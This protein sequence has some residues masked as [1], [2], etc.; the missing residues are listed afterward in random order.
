MK[1]NPCWMMALIALLG[2]AIGQGSQAEP[3]PW[4]SL[5]GP[6]GGSVAALAM[7]PNYPIDHTVFAGLRGQGVYRTTD[8]GDSW[9]P[10][11]PGGWVV[12]DLAISPA[13]ADDQTVFVSTGLWTTGYHIYRSTDEGITWQD[14]TP[15]WSGLPNVPRLAISPDF[16]SDRTIYVLGTLQT[17]VSTDGGDTFTLATGWL[18]THNVSHL[19]FSPAYAMDHTLF[20][21]VPSDGLYK[22]SDGGTTWEATGS[23]DNLSTFAVSPDYTND[24]TLLAVL[25]SSGRLSVSTDG[26]NSWAENT[27]TPDPA[28]QHT[29]LFSPTFSSAD[30]VILAASS[31]DPGPY[32]SEDGGTTWSAVEGL[33]GGSV[34]ALALA[35]ASSFDAAAYAG[36]SSGIHRSWNRG[37]HWGQSS[38]G[39]PRLTIL[40][41]TIAPGDPDTMLAGTSFFE[42][43][44][45][46]T[47]TP[48]EYDGNLQLSTDGGQTWRAVSGQL[49]RVQNV[50]FSPDFVNDQSAFAATGTLGQHGYFGGNVY[51]S[52]DGGHN[53]SAVF[54]NLI[55]KALAISPNYAA[56]QTLWVS[57]FTDSAA[58]GIYVSHHGG[59][60]WSILTHDIHAEVLAP[61]PN[62][63]VDGTLF[64][65]TYDNGLQRSTD[66]GTLWTR[67]LN[68][69]VT[70]LAVSTAYGASRTLYVGVKDTPGTAG[71]IYRSSNGG[72]TWQQLDTG[73]PGSHNSDPLTISV[74][75]FAA[76]GSVLAGVYYGSE[77]SGGAVYRSTDGGGTWQAVGDGLEPYNVFALATIPSASIKFYAGTNTLQGTG[78]GLWQIEVPQGGPA[79]PGTWETHGPRGG[80]TLALE[81]SPD[82][83]HDGLALSG[84]YRPGRYGD[85]SGLGIFRSTDGGQTWQ[86]S[87]SGTEGRQYTSAIHDFAFSPDFGSASLTTSAADQTV[88][89]ATWGGLF[90]STDGGQHWQWTGR[91]F[92]GYPG[93]ITAVAVAP[94]FATSG[95]VIAG[96]GWGGVFVSRD[97]GTNWTEDSTVAAATGIVYSPD[98]GLD[99][100]AFAGAWGLWKTTDGGAG[101]SQVMTEGISALAISPEFGTDGTLFVGRSDGLSISHDGGTSWIS[102]T[103]S[104]ES[105]FITALAVSPQFGTDQTLFAGNNKTLHRSTDG[106]LSWAPVAGYPDLPVRSL[107]LSPSW[108]AHPVLLAGTDQGVYRT[109]DGGLTW[110][111]TQGL[112][113]CGVRALTMPPSESPLVVGTYRQGVHGSTSGGQD[114]FP[115][116]LQDRA[117]S[118][119]W[120][121]AISPDYDTDQTVFALDDY[122]YCGGDVVRTTDGG[123]T[124]EPVWGTSYPGPLAISPQYGDDHTVFSIADGYVVM[125]SFD[126]GDTWDGVGQW[127]TSDYYP[128]RVVA[129]PPNYSADS[130]IFAG[131]NG[132]WRLPPGATT[133]EL[134]A[135]GLVTGTY[136]GTLAVSPNYAADSTLLATGWWYEEGSVPRDGLFRST[137]GGVHWDVVGTGLPDEFG[138]P[139]GFS[140]NYA[141]DRVAYMLAGDQL[142]RSLDGGLSWTRI[143]APP[144]H[145]ALSDLLVGQ[146]G[147]VHV[148]SSAGVWRY[149]TPAW[150]I[151]VNGGFEADSGWDLP[152]TPGP[153]GYSPQIAYHGERSLR[154]GIVNTSNKH[155]YSSGR[156]I[157]T[158]PS[159]TLTATL[160]CDVYLV[161]NESVQV[162]LNQ[163]FSEGGV[164][165]NLAGAVPQAGDAQYL[166]ILEPDAS[167]ILNKLF[168][169]LSNSQAWQHYSFDLSAYA[170][171]TIRLHFG[172]Y[173]DGAGGQTG[174]YVDNV[175]LI[176][177]RP[178]PERPV[179]RVHLPV[180]LKSYESPVPI[181]VEHVVV[182]GPTSGTF[183]L[184]YTFTAAASP[185]SATL[186]ITYT[187][188]A[189]GQPPVTHTDGLSDTVSFTWSTTGTQAITV[190]ANNS[191]GAVTGTHLITISQ[192]TVPSGPLLIDGQWVFR[193]VGH[194]QSA[195]VY[196]LT[197]AGLYRSDD[198]AHTWTLMNSSP[199]VTHSLVLA[200]SQ[201][202]VLYADASM[203]YPCYRGGPNAPMWKSTDS[204]Q[205]WFELPAGLNLEPMA[206]HPSNPQRVYARGCTT[207]WFSSDGGNTWTEQPDDLFLLWDVR[208]IAP[209]DDWQ[210]VYLGCTSEGGAG[211]IIG[212]TNG[213]TNWDLL[214][215]TDP[216]PWWVSALAVDPISPPHVYFGEPHSFWGSHDGGTTWFTSTNGLE[217]VVY[218]PSGPITQ[219]YGLLSLAYVPSDLDHWLL[220]TVGGLHRTA[221]RGQTWT[222]FTGTPW[223]NEWIEELLLRWIEPD[224]LFLTTP[225]GVYVYHLYSFPGGSAGPT[226]N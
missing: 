30:R 52:T 137:D 198:G 2:L 187:W 193:V 57:A 144:G 50:V 91:I 192:T 36:T 172:V 116:G 204:G 89:A 72:A 80:R 20:A 208:S 31:S 128:A 191:G 27:L 154:V 182:S 207:P 9:H 195:T 48:G 189:T 46:D 29:L 185:A 93:S 16:A 201:P 82:F 56:D 66:S 41:L 205:T 11:G 156:Q 78:G 87:S 138:G 13:Y 47:A 64:A 134:A 181:A 117:S 45:F 190:T 121:V 180:I 26:G 4:Q 196:G 107:A 22:S 81:V 5:P 95:H 157:V 215:P 147:D 212:S 218:D 86:T 222:R 55:C 99:S 184:P 202:S 58:W 200:P 100:T 126:G 140:A 96:S 88:F 142:Y 43:L 225:S 68:H 131:A 59:D 37:A 10:L 73:I 168:W 24:Q 71:Q 197:T 79:E 7:S 90:K 3:E 38:N 213:G 221:D 159:D 217:D 15:A 28:G 32:R 109:T 164:V 33:V 160:H 152:V 65:G 49:E 178:V 113:P 124:W 103:V 102:S 97:G 25:A 175:S 162:S 74:L 98:F 151:I 63:A 148:A 163:A 141:T 60:N 176:I 120:D 129:L 34:F 40:A 53:W 18:A 210:T 177:Q 149:S 206:V 133:W 14:V 101:W 83:A 179:Y 136:V 226:P 108:P 6:Y 146:D 173:N 220:G 69:P 216:A 106:G 104:A 211:A 123:A 84:E 166:L 75:A 8:L 150:D 219:T 92:R 174:M 143:G 170:G 110:V 122:A 127:P 118:D 155:A 169:K 105:P 62:Y 199:I 21:L 165:D 161:S 153:A 194:P 158:V 67:V 70:A 85:Q 76:D 39:L 171:Q 139:V 167:R 114:W 17:Y 94:D 145:L 223:E 186:P 132:F 224:K 35:P 111:R 12:T 183:N 125:G 44:R 115:M 119:V 188:Q 203:G 130:T 23:P 61:S 112:T 214:T 42:H 1:R 51:R 77:E 135:S 209:A 54:D 19:G